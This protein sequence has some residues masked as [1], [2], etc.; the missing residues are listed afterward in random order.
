ERIHGGNGGIGGPLQPPTISI[1]R[2][3][4]M[5]RVRVPR[6]RA[7]VLGSHERPRENH[8]ASLRE[9]FGSRQDSVSDRVALW[10]RCRSRAA[11]TAKTAMTRTA[12]LT[13]D[14]VE[15][16]RRTE[17]GV[18]SQ[19]VRRQRSSKALRYRLDRARRPTVACCV[20]RWSRN[21]QTVRG[22]CAESLAD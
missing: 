9:R 1:K 10:L 15:D 17:R 12:P 5:K 6:A 7:A 11:M 21:R 16:D 13:Q 19:A 2:C 20:F 8:L 18:S 4:P 14:L 22:R 3:S